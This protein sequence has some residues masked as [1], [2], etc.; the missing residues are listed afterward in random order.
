MDRCEAWKGVVP[1]GEI[2]LPGRPYQEAVDL[3]VA[4]R[5]WRDVAV[6]LAS[7]GSHSSV[8][9]T[10][11]DILDLLPPGPIVG[12]EIGVD[13]GINARE[14]LLQRP[15]LYLWTVDPWTH[16][17]DFTEVGRGT[18][19][20]FYEERVGEFVRAGRTQHLRLSSVEAAE[21]L[22]GRVDYNGIHRC[23][24]FDFIYIDA[25]HSEEAVRED[26]AIWWPLLLGGGLMAGHD[27]EA[28]S[29]HTPVI[30]FAKAHRLDLGIIN[31]HGGLDDMG[32]EPEG[33]AWTRAVASRASRRPGTGYDRWGGWAHPSW[34]FFKPD[35]IGNMN[36][37][38]RDES[39]NGSGESSVRDLGLEPNDLNPL[40]N[41]ERL[42]RI[43][44]ALGAIRELGARRSAAMRIFGSGATEVL[45]RRGISL[46]AEDKK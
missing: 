29:V 45:K 13:T 25:D 14:L 38:I 23:M 19:L 26:I 21:H 34:F 39:S 44:V 1:I 9:T 33:T 35:G 15:D 30:Q 37:V 6:K 46:V 24:S 32:L 17:R 41:D 4:D 36:R 18:A 31:E 11:Y 10:R 3:G 43:A 27:F 22:S 20:H 7:T 12:V 5:W 16:D 2:L 28:P 40:N 8:P 42:D